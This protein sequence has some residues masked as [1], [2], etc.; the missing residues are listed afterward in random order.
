M[1]VRWS[2]PKET[3][4]SKLLPPGSSAVSDVFS[5]I[6]EDEAA[7]GKGTSEQNSLILTFPSLKI[8]L[9]GPKLKGVLENVISL[10]APEEKTGW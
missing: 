3:Q 4:E 2:S 10:S 1:W 7:E 8:Q 5:L 6:L 9:H